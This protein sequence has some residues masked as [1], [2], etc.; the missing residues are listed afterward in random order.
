MCH[1]N[2]DREGAK[3]SGMFEDGQI[4]GH[5]KKTKP[6]SLWSYEGMWQKGQRHGQGK[7]TSALG[8]ETFE[9]EFVN[10]SIR[11]QGSLGS[12]TTWSSPA[13]Y[14]TQHFT[15]GGRILTGGELSTSG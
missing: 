2:I 8:D 1:L 11:G 10:N 15:T 13:H 12:A 3:Y 6:N 7:F 14:A 9:G 5:G 4:N